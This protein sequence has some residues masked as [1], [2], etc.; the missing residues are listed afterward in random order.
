M[1]VSP[2][3][4]TY[5]FKFDSVISK[6]KISDSDIIGESPKKILKCCRLCTI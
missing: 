1:S 6:D 5:N 2:N 4:S 3:N